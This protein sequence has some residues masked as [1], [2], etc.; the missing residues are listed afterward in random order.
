MTPYLTNL[1]APFAFTPDYTKSNVRFILGYSAVA[2]AAFT[3]YADRNLGWE[4]TTSPWIIAAVGSYFVLNSALTFWIW[5]V[6]AGQVFQGKR[7]TGE[8]VCS[9]DLVFF[10]SK[11]RAITS[12]SHSIRVNVFYFA[13]MLTLDS[14]DLDFLVC[15][16]AHRAL[17]IACCIQG[18]LRENSPG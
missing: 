13:Q 12:F 18:P 14:V 5:A 7:Q 16:E 15:Q 6:E 10:V 11:A 17:Q 8:T 4:A 2:I 3:F 1:P 9:L